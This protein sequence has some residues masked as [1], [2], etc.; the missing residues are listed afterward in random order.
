L[1]FLKNEED[2]ETEYN[3]LEDDDSYCLLG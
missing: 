2:E 3:I 1:E